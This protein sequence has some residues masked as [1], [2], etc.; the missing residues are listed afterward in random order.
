MNRKLAGRWGEALVASWLRERGWEI[1]GSNY[2][3]RFGEIDLIAANGKYIAFVEVKLRKNADF[4][5]AAEAV[6]GRKQARI[7]TCAEL[8]LSQRDCSLQPRFDV[9]ELYGEG[10]GA[11]CSIRYMENAF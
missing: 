7:R 8:Y 6:D 1:L 4:A 2:R 5:S 11:P 10:P 9:A 3:T